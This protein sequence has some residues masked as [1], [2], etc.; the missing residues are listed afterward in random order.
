MNFINISLRRAI[1]IT[2][3]HFNVPVQYKLFI[4]TFLPFVT[5]Q[6]DLIYLI[7]IHIFH[8]N[9]NRGIKF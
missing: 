8:T 7:I 5:D 2:I 6:L 9:I 4:Y 1:L 3:I